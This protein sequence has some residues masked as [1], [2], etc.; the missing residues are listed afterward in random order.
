MNT[1]FLTKRAHGRM[2]L[3]HKT[4]KFT[5]SKRDLKSIFIT[6]IRPVLEQSSS[7]WQSSLTDENKSDLERVQKAALKLIMDNDYIDYNEPL[8]ALNISDLA[9]RREKLIKNMA[10]KITNY[11]KVKKICYH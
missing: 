11:P 4:A 10:I 6:F 9:Q 1:K 8:K 5:K 3:L 2:Q 7:V